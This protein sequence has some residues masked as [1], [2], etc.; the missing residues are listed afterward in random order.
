MTISDNYV[1]IKLSCNGTTKDFSFPWNPV[2]TAFVEVYLEDKSTG[3]RTLQVEGSDYTLYVNPLG[4]GGKA[5]FITAPSSSYYCL[6]KR[7]TN[8]NQNTP[9]ETSDG[10][11]GFNFE[12]SFDKLTAMLQENLEVSD[13]SFKFADGDNGATEFPS[14]STGVN[15]YPFYNGTKWAWAS[16]TTTTPI[17]TAMEDF[18]SSASLTDARTELD[19]YSKSETYTKTEVDDKVGANGGCKLFYSST[20]ELNMSP[21]NGN[22]LNINGTLETVTST[23][24]SNS[25][26]SAD[27]LYYVYAYMD[28][29]TMKL[30]LSTTTYTTG[31]YGVMI[32]T[33]DGSQTLV[34]MIYTDGSGQFSNATGDIANYYNR[35][36][37]VIS[38]GFDD[39]KTVTSNTFVEIDS[40]IRCNFLSWGDGVDA[41]FAGSASVSNS[42]GGH[43]TTG[44]SL[45]GSTPYISSVGACYNSS[46]KTNA[47][48]SGKTTPSLG[49]HYMTVMGAKDSGSS[50]GYWQGATLAQNLGKLSVILKI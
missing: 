46:G 5:T 19:V 14:S 32:K 4:I 17:S 6:I 1:P 18:V 33:G 41:S 23:N 7:K 24:V 26:L 30:T 31:A 35:D 37:I 12:Y 9:Y 36:C 3:V 39:T 29:S 42:S 50:Y 25:G 16:G 43:A 15:K 47:S 38:A 27:T 40:M 49:R 8:R 21:Y 48:F 13:R 2:S 45:D 11:N 34:G 28:G 20:T 44:I 22:K 10:F